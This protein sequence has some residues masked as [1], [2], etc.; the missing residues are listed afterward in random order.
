[1][2]KSDLVGVEVRLVELK[3]PKEPKMKPANASGKSCL[4]FCMTVYAELLNR[5]SQRQ[6]LA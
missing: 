5:L 1:M 2:I 3:E 4:S 6:A